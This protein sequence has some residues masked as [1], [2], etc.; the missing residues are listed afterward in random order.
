MTPLR[1]FLT[2]A[3][4]AILAIGSASAQAP[5]DATP[6]ALRGVGLDQHLGEEVPLELA[7]VNESGEAVHLADY[8]DERPVIL[9]LNYYQCP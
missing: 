8:F 5:E 2:A 1:S 7:F 3:I 9:T 4:L 6:P